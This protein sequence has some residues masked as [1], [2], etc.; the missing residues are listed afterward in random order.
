MPPPWD[1]V[2][3]QCVYPAGKQIGLPEAHIFDQRTFSTASGPWAR[4]WRRGSLGHSFESLP[5]G[6]TSLGVRTAPGRH[7]PIRIRLELD[8]PRDVSIHRDHHC[9]FLPPALLLG[10][11]GCLGKLTSGSQDKSYLCSW[12]LFISASQEPS[13]PGTPCLNRCPLRAPPPA[14]DRPA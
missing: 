14:S 13:V 7:V 8:W 6:L 3:P 11:R 9:P 4:R 10:T 12:S 1:L 2:Q 5:P